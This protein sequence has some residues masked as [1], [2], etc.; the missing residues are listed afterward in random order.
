MFTG[1]AEGWLAPSGCS[2]TA[3]DIADH[4]AE[5]TATDPFTI[6][7]SIYDEVFGFCARLG[8]AAG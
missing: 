3:D 1:L 4:L 7:G 6:P 5:V 8:I 2:P